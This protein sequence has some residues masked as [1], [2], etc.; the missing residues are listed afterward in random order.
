[1]IYEEL[2]FRPSSGTIDR[3]SIT[4]WLAS[5]DYA[6]LDPIEGETWHLSAT[7]QDMETH[8]HERIVNPTCMPWGVFVLLRDRSATP[9]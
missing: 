8:R 1:M 7:K 4:A 9:G 5:K 3:G 2:K 6:F